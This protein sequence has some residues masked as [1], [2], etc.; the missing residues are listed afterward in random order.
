MAR[1]HETPTEARERQGRRIA[2]EGVDAA[3]EA[4]IA[5]CRDP[6]APAPAKSS[7]G[8]ALLRAGGWF[9]ARDPEDDIPPHEMTGEQLQR[10]IAR[11]R[12]DSDALARGEAVEDEASD[13]QGGVFS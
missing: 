10:A 7:A 4:L 9:N 3:I 6:K 11:L 2:T 13:G 5:T 8:T 1:N 12:R